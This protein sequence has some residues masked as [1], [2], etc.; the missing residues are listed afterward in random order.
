MTLFILCIAVF[1]AV[2]IVLLVTYMRELSHFRDSQHAY[3]DVMN[4]RR[5]QDR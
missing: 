1:L 2:L 5:N 4:A 3:Q